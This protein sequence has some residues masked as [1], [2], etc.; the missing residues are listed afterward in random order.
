MSETM[1]TLRE[2]FEVDVKDISVRAEPG[3]DIYQGAKKAREEITRESRA[4]RWPWVRQAVAEETQDLLN[5]NVVEVLARAWKQFMKLEECADPNKHG[6]GEKILVPLAEH[7]LNSVHHP[8]VQILLKG[9]EVGSVKCD[10]QF[11]LIL[12]GFV[13]LIQDGRILEIQAG[14]ASGE[15]SLSLA[16]ISLWKSEMKPVH[17]PGRIS[18]GKGIPLRNAGDSH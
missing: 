1:F 14:S 8:S 11:S 13:L 3:L 5:L 4:I 17:F 9:R 10:L 15:G 16:E 7:T 12:E 2:L 18:L 6:R